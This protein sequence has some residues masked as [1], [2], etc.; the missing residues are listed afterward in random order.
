[1]ESAL[2][3]HASVTAVPAGFPSGQGCRT[4]TEGEI[5]LMNSDKPASLDSR[6]FYEHASPLQI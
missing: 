1:M 4:I 5:F 3:Q 6:Y 2:E